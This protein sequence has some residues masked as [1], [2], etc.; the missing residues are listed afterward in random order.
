M[1]VVVTLTVNDVV[2]VELAVQ[3]VQLLLVHWKW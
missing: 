3:W 1:K 2:V